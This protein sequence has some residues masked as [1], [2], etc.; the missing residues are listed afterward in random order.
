MDKFSI[1]K[2]IK[3]YRT[4]QNIINPNF[5]NDEKYIEDY[6]LYSWGRICLG[7]YRYL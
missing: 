1:E 2:N 6:Y 4:I 3:L 5:I 7:K